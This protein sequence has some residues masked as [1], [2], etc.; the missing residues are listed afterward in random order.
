[1]ALPH[2]WSGNPDARVLV[3][4]NSLGTVQAMWD[5]VMPWFEER[6]HV[7]TYDL[8]GHFG[9]SSGFTF[10]SM[11]DETVGLLDA[12]GIQGAAMAGVSV[13]G[14][15]SVAT[16]AAR[17]DLVSATVAINAPI[18]QASAQFWYD[19]AESVGRDGLGP[20]ADGMLQRW[21]S[22]ETSAAW[23]IIDQFLALDPSGYAAA[24]RA[25]AELDVTDDADRVTVPTLIV[26][27]SDDVSVPPANAEE[28]ARRIPDSVLWRVDDGGHLL[29]VRR[30]E[31][32]GPL[33]TAFA[34]SRVG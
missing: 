19:R 5:E 4:S 14:A 3:L 17:P 21:F 32:V 20:I 15:I 33:V 1:M 22:E 28:L 10:R 7:L 26:A 34:V 2:S 18:R 6:F 31:V 8:P 23:R 11:V 29:P 25:L 9:P 27:A 24:C 13:G 30:P 12:L 16:A